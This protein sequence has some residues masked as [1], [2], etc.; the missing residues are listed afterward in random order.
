MPC[1]DPEQ[2][3]EQLLRS[4][5]VG[6]SAFTGLLRSLTADCRT[7]T[8]GVVP[9]YVLISLGDAMGRRAREEDIKSIKACWCESGD[10][11]RTILAVVLSRLAMICPSE[12]SSSLRGLEC[13]G[14]MLLARWVYPILGLW[15]TSHLDSLERRDLFLMSW[16]WYARYV[17]EDFELAL[18]RVLSRSDVVDRYL[19]LALKELRKVNPSKVVERLRDRPGLLKKVV[20]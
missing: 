20:P 10:E 4:M 3:A 9:K 12:V 13:G 6:C 5:R 17:P 7:P 1:P 16:A 2:V 19:V 14:M 18:D 8:R 15:D 11:I